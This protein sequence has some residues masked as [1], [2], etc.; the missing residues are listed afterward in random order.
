MTSKFSVLLKKYSIPAIF[1]LI[2]IVMIF[3]GISRSQDSTFMIAA[4]MMFAA[5]LVSVLYSSGNLKPSFVYI[6]GIVAGIAAAFTL[7]MSYKSVDETNTYNKN[8]AMCKNLSIQNLQD[9]RYVQ[10]KYYE[11]NGKYIDNWDDLVKY[12][13]T[14]TIPSVVSVGVVPND[15]ITRE[16]C[17]YLY[18]DNRAID[19]NMTEEEAY[20]LSKWTEGPR[21]ATMFS[22]FKRDTVQVSLMDTKF[23]SNSY[24]KAREIAGFP[25]FSPDSLPFIPFTGAREKWTME[26]ADSVM[27]G[28]A[29][30]AAIHVE[31]LM[32]FSKVQGT[33]NEKISFGKITSNDTAGSWEDE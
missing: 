19:N 31:G 22:G 24:V 18:G 15:K 6:I 30:V 21:Y 32:P 9:I 27:M 25:A 14:G 23:K 11:Q 5:G 4:I 7:Y 28:D 20:R 8:Y 26:V 33:A 10:K 1:F 2:G 13:K 3:F 12:V 29:K 17:K 16:E